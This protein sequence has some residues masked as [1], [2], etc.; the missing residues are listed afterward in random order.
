MLADGTLVHCDP[1][2][3]VVYISQYPPF[4][5]P[6]QTPLFASKK[7]S[8]MGC[9]LGKGKAV[10]CEVQVM[11]P[12]VVLKTPPPVEIPGLCNAANAVFASSAAMLTPK[13]PVAPPTTEDVQV[14]PA[15]VVRTNWEVKVL[16]PQQ[17]FSFT[18]ESST[19]GFDDTGKPAAR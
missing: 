2:F 19:S 16:I 12:S 15:F 14:V 3:V 8:A 9:P 17:T 11:P 5:F 13:S 1:P 10:G 6:I 18:A 7:C 4:G